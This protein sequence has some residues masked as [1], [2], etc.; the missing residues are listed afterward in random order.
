MSKILLATH[1]GAGADGAVRVASLLAPRVGA[2]LEALVVLEPMPVVD[3]GFGVVASCSAEE[4]EAIDAQL[5]ADASAQLARYDA[6]GGALRSCFGLPADE[7]AG[8]ARASDA[9]TIVVGLGPHGA[10]ARALGQE[11]ALQLVQIAST[12]ILAVPGDAT[13]LPHRVVAAVDFTPTSIRAARTAARWL[14]AGDV[15]HLVHVR[16]G[17]HAARAGADLPFTDQEDGA[18][19]EALAHEI[20]VGRGVRVETAVVDGEPAPALLDFAARHDA[21]LIALGSHGYGMWKRLTLGSVAS[22]IVRLTTKSVLV[23]PIR[24]LPANA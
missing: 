20:A 3:Y 24:C 19:L 14:V 22:K 2:E 4:E 12:P 9:E 11:T 7:I 1:G 17:H 5:V 10:V 23:V 6:A 16:A 8:A 18:R 13:E 21:D 15:L